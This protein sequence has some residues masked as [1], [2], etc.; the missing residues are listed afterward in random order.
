[1]QTIK[2]TQIR[3][4]LTAQQELFK[5]RQLGDDDT[6]LEIQ[7]IM[8]NFPLIIARLEQDRAATERT[9]EQRVQALE[10]KIRLLATPGYCYRGGS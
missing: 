8:A 9:L 1:M 2:Q 10:E 5:A 6:A 4:L 3:H 7:A